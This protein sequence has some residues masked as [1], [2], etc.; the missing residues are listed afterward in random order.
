MF[1]RWDRGVSAPRSAGA[2]DDGPCRRPRPGPTALR[3]GG[4]PAEPEAQRLPARRRHERVTPDVPLAL[5]ARAVPGGAVHLDGEPDVVVGGVEDED[6]PGDLDGALE[7]ELRRARRTQHGQASPDL[8]FTPAPLGQEPHQRHHLGPSREAWPALD[9]EEQSLRPAQAAPDR[10]DGRSTD[11]RSGQSSRR[12]PRVDHRPLRAGH[13]QPIDPADAP[14][15]VARPVQ[16][17][18]LGPAS[19]PP[20]RDRE[21]DRPAGWGELPQRQCRPVAD[22]PAARPRRG[23]HPQPPVAGHPGQGVDAGLDAHES[24]GGHPSGHRAAV[25]PCGEHLPGDPAVRADDGRGV[26]CHAA[27]IDVRPVVVRPPTAPVDALAPGG[28]P[29]VCADAARGATECGVGAHA[30]RPSRRRQHDG[31]PPSRGTG[32]RGRVGAVR[33]SS[34]GARGWACAARSSG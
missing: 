2:G 13:R 14:V 17:D 32:R 15:E 29:G 30:R 7:G 8:E 1:R 27:S 34:R 18:A 23:L 22:H 16:H 20:V 26:V 6:L 28:R 19:A 31:P 25:H 5:A 9:L 33:R 4:H 24:A 3:L 11:C 21:V 10:I 12:P